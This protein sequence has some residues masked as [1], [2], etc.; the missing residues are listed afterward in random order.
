MC[1][2]EGRLDQHKGDIP[3]VS[4]GTSYYTSLTQSEHHS[5]YESGEKD[6]DP[7]TTV[8]PLVGIRGLKTPDSRP[9]A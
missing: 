6:F 5:P 3:V 8:F 9:K 4:L 7:A 2:V 1:L